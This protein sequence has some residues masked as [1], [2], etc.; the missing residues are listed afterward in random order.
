MTDNRFVHCKT[1][2][3]RVTEGLL[4]EDGLKEP[5]ISGSSVYQIGGQPGHRPEELIF[6]MKSIIGKYRSENKQI[7]LQSFDLEK[8]FDKE[9]IED[10]VLACLKRGADPKAV[11]CW[12]KLNANTN[13]RVRTPAG[14][15]EPSN[16]GAVVGQGILGGALVSQAVVDEGMTEH[17]QPG[18]DTEL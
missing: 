9:R 17:F 11:R 12:Y 15:S 14:V 18:G 2:L 16:V 5:L 8:F 10:A 3:P 13:I 4:V 6:V 7:I 1:W